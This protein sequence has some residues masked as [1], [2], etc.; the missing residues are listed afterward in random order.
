MPIKRQRGRPPKSERGYDDTRQVLIQSGVELLTIYGYLG[1]GVDAIVKKAN[2]P[3]GSFYHYFANKEAFGHAVLEAYGHYFA[4]K[5]DKHLGIEAHPPLQRLA[6]FVEDAKAGMARY[7]FCRGCLVGNMLQEVPQLSEQFAQQLQ[8][9]LADWQQRIAD[10]LA[11]AKAC[12][13]IRADIDETQM[14]ELFWSGWEG[15]VMRAKLF[16]STQPLD[17]FWSYFIKNL[18]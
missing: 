10:C 15:A 8:Q 13:N 16:K 6:N 1:S 4:H 18:Q 3:K 14:A 2:V 11:Q 5:L 9:I 17:Q 7:Q 12:Q